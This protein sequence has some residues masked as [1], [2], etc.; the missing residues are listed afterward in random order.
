MSLLKIREF[1]ASYYNSNTLINIRQC[2]ALERRGGGWSRGRGT[3]GSQHGCHAPAPRRPSPASAGRSVFEGIMP[4]G[5]HNCIRTGG[6]GL[7]A[8]IRLLLQLL[9]LLLAGFEQEADPVCV[10]VHGEVRQPGAGVG[11]HHDLVPALHVQD[12]VLPGHR[13]LVVVLVVLVEDGGDLLAVLPDGEQR[14]L[15]VVGGNVEHEEVGAASGAGEDTS[16]GVQ[17]STDV[18]VGPV[19]GEVLLTATVVGLASVGIEVNAEGLP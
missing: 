2:R 19:E 10:V 15:V 1:Y 9:S 11:V 7:I 3:A 5:G 8:L 16:V 13:V 12:D 4:L 14:L 18:A 17:T 6:W